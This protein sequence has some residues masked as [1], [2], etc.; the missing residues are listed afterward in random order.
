MEKIKV[1]DYVRTKDGE[2]TRIVDTN[3]FDKTIYK[4]IQGAKYYLEDIVKHSP[5]IIDLIEVGD[6]VNGKLIHKVDIGKNYAYI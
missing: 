5:N 6:Y 3:M 1:G 4:D 2:I